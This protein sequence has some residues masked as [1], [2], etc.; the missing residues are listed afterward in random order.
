M[1]GKI[2]INYRRDDDPGNTG[3]L[4]DRLLETFRPQQL[5]MDVDSIAPGLDFVKV[6]EEQVAESDVMISVIGKAWLDARDETGVRRLDNPN[7]FVRIEIESALKQGKLVIPVLVGKAEMPHPNVL[8]ET[9]RPLSRR[10]AVRLTHERFHSDAQ[11]LITAL[12]QILENA[13]KAAIQFYSCFLIYSAK[14]VEFAKRIHAD[15]QND[16]VRCWLAPQDMPIGGKILD[17][18]DAAIRL[19]DKVLVVLSE[20]SVKSDWV[21]DAVTKGFEEERRRGQIV[22]FP[23]RLD[24]TV[25]ETTE[26]WAAKLRARLIGDFQHWKDHDAYKQ[27]FERV[28]RDLTIKR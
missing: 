2:F 9:I 1:A 25:M 21:E 27:N 19:R 14:D 5:F 12:E 3:R 7:D 16:G 28:L 8:P 20:H 13:R 10:N 15:L 24:E 26:A 22:L 17:E 6:L 18:I 11:G 4:F 23:L